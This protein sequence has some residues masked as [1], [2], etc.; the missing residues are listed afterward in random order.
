[1]IQVSRGDVP[2]PAAGDERFAV[3]ALVRHRRYGYR[4]VVVALDPTCRARDEWYESNLSQPK[5]DQPW[6]H[7][8]VHGAAHTTYAAESNLKADTVCAPVVHPWIEVFFSEFRGNYY[9]RNER[10]WPGEAP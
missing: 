1:M 7:V 6:Y 5:R 10:P 8:L 3:G 4:G 9:V 2:E